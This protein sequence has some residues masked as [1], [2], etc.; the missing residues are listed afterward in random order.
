MKQ[1]IIC[2]SLAVAVIILFL[3]VGIQPAIASENPIYPIPKG[4]TLYVGG[5]GEGNYT[6]ISYAIYD[7]NPGDT[8][9]VYDDSS[10]YYEHLWISKSINLIGENRDTTVI[11]GINISHMNGIEIKANYVNVSGFTIIHSGC[12]C[13]CVLG[14]IKIFSK[15]CTISGNNFS[16]DGICI[17]IASANNTIENNI[18]T[19][20]WGGIYILSSNNLIT[21]NKI[22]NNGMGIEIWGDNNTISGNNISN[23]GWGLEIGLSKFNLILK[24]NF[25]DNEYHAFFEVD[26]FTR[27]HWKHNYWGKPRILPKMIFGLWYHWDSGFSI[28]WFNIDWRPALKPYDIEV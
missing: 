8:V 28:P 22:S 6:R 17:V 19:N 20:S 11:D 1:R 15:Y 14:A 4:K 3:G 25:I 9:Y 24:N 26:T 2:K 12:P 13:P 23:N 16:D 7:A 21:G 18:I 10:P 5:S 27:N